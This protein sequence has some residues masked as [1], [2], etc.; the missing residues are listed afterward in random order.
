MGEIRAPERLPD[1]AA[2]DEH[3]WL[4]AKTS[5]SGPPNS[6]ELISIAAKSIYAI[7][8]DVFN[9]KIMFGALRCN[10]HHATHAALANESPKGS[11]VS[12]PVNYVP[13]LPMGGGMQLYA[14]RWIIVIVQEA[15]RVNISRV[16]DLKW[17][18]AAQGHCLSAS[19]G[20][21]SDRRGW[22]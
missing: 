5:L 9:Y 21:R 15:C 22:R 14:M 10:T 19:Y 12:I 3:A 13:I 1:G 17:P 6:L 7:S 20:Y 16:R 2:T 8:I 18:T 11:S 4:L